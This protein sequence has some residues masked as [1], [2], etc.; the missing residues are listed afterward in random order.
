MPV[1]LTPLGWRASLILA[2]AGRHPASY[3]ISWYGEWSVRVSSKKTKTA[4]V[5]SS[6]NVHLIPQHVVRHDL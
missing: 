2:M 4:T 6:G 5:F 3:I 1:R